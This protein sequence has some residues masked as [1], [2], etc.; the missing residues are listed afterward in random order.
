MLCHANEIFLQVIEGSREEVS[1]LL[2]RLY[3]DPRHKGLQLLSFE[4]ITQR[5]F[6][7]W[8]MGKVNMSAI[9]AA[10]LL[11]YSEKAELNPFACTGPA[12]L[13]LLLEIAE[14]GAIAHRST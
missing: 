11:K 12:T 8:T 13:H 10:L 4:E 2:G 3:A 14:V 1:G 6:G 5:R 7:N 9:N